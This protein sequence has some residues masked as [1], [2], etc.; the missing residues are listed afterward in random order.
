MTNTNS[1]GQLIEQMHEANLQVAESTRPLNHLDDLNLDQRARLRA[2]I[3]TCLERWDKVAAA[4]D[5]ALT[6]TERE[7]GFHV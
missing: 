1:L 2:Q 7:R 4:I 3:R 6:Q 5:R